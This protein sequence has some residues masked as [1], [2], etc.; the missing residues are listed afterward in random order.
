MTVIRKSFEIEQHGDKGSFQR[1]PDPKSQ[2]EVS[3]AAPPGGAGAPPHG[4]C[5]AAQRGSSAGGERWRH[6]EGKAAA[7]RWGGGSEG[8]R[9][10]L[11]RRGGAV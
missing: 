10:P 3:Q 2:P 9:E 7:A 6:G 8:R 5:L 1:F 11:G 4:R